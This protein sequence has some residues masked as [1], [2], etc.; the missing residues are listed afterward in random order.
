MASAHI[1][2][3]GGRTPGT[4]VREHGGFRLFASE[5]AFYVLDGALFRPID[6][7][8]RAARERLRPCKPSGRMSLT[9]SEAV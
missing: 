1:V 2:E 5:R 4:I 6:Q 3:V 9:R 8:A 7:A